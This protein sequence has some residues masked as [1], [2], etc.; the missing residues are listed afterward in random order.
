MKSLVL[1]WCILN[2]FFQA[3][4]AYQKSLSFL[5]TVDE[6]YTLTTIHRVNILWKKAMNSSA[7]ETKFTT[8]LPKIDV[9]L[10]CDSK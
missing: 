3:L 6:W 2:R 10:R 1:D 7:S 8:Y 9:Y 4:V 5:F